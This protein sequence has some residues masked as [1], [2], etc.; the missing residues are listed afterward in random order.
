MKEQCAWIA[1]SV[2]S[3][4]ERELDD[5]VSVEQYLTRRETNIAVYALLAMI[6]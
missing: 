5:P 3:A 1:S 6:P 2:Q 4:T